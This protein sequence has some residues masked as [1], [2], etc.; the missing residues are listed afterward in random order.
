MEK[1]GCKMTQQNQD[2]TQ[3]NGLAL[4]YIGDAVY[5]VFI[6]QYLLETGKTRP[7]DLHKS[8][9]TFVSAK[10][11]SNLIKEMLEIGYL[12]EEEEGIFKRGRNAKSHS[13]AK[14]ADVATYRASTGFESLMGYLHM[15]GQTDRLKEVAMWCIHRMEENKNGKE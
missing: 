14:N 12:T 2:W 8:A 9:T 4:A 13:S 7:N 1:R 11:Q 6:R 15:T 10:G 3:L 5:E